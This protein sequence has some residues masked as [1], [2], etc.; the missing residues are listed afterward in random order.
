[1]SA[2]NKTNECGNEGQDVKDGQQEAPANL[3]PVHLPCFS[4][5]PPGIPRQRVIYNLL[6][7]RCRQQKS[8][9]SFKVFAKH[10]IY[11]GN[12]H[13][14]SKTLRNG[15][16]IGPKG[17]NLGPPWCM[18][19]GSISFPSEAHYVAELESK[20][21]LPAIKRVFHFKFFPRYRTAVIDSAMSTWG[22]V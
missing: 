7:A 4:F 19:Y 22:F 18:R 16:E 8:G 6:K 12:F 14:L 20:L 15:Q 11:P 21:N 3:S 13:R 2:L 9:E 17:L 1:V 10:P 5:S